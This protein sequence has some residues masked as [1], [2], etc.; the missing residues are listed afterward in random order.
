MVTFVAVLELAGIIWAVTAWR[1]RRRAGRRL[2]RPPAA[3]RWTPPDAS[4]PT[5]A[6]VAG[7][8]TGH[9][10]AAGHGGFPGDPLPGGHLGSPANLAYWGGMFEDEA[11]LD[12][13]AADGSDDDW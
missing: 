8:L 10:I 5:G 12:D 2:P 4:D 7:W 13:G 1:Q 11:D 9:Q 6:P 3:A